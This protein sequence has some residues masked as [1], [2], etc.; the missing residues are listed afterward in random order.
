[1]ATEN[2]AI[3]K[4]IQALQAAV[5]VVQKVEKLLGSICVEMEHEAQA[6]VARLLNVEM[7]KVMREWAAAMER[8][9]LSL[10]AAEEA[11]ESIGKGAARRRPVATASEPAPMEPETTKPP[12]SEAVRFTEANRDKAAE[13]IAK[14]DTDRG[15]TIDDIARAAATSPAK[16]VSGCGDEIKAGWDN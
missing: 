9:G 8:V 2:R 11:L 14:E 5:P 1:M 3:R 4:S 15:V 12:E 7:E 16:S 10:P 6:R 13:A